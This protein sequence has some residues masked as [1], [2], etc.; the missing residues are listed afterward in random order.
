[1]AIIEV[2]TTNVAAALAKALV[3]LWL[4]DEGRVAIGEGIIETLKKRFEDYH[5][6]RSAETLL[7]NVE[8]DVAARLE[9][10]IST[11]FRG[12]AENEQEAAAYAVGN[13]IGMLSIQSEL[14]RA[15]LDATRLEIAVDAASPAA[16]TS[17]GVHTPTY[18]LAKHLLTECCRY[19]VVMAPQ[20]PQYDV[21]ATRELLIRGTT[22]LQ[23]L[24]SVLD[25]LDAIKRAT[26][27]GR[28][29]E[30]AEFEDRYRNTLAQILDRIEIFG[31]RITGAATREYALTRAYVPISASRVAT[32]QLCQLDE[33][34]MQERLVVVRGDAGSGKSTLMQWLAVQA[35]RRK[36]VA[37]LAHWNERIPFYVRLREYQDETKELPRPTQF[38]SESLRHLIDLVPAGWTDQSLSAGALLLIDGVDELPAKRRGR[39]FDW[40]RGLKDA[41]P[42]T[43]VLVS[44]RPAALD[45]GDPTFS[46]RLCS[47]GFVELALEPMTPNDSET[48]TIR[49]HAE[50]ARGLADKAILAAL[51]RNERS[52]RQALRER[53]AIRNLASSP[54]LCAMM[55]VLNWDQ[56]SNL[57]D[58]RMQ[59]YRLALDLLLERRESDREIGPANI[60]LDRQTKET[61][62]DGLAYW[63]LRNGMTEAGRPE[64]EKQIADMLPGLPHLP[65]SPTLIMDELVERS[66]VLRQPQY[67]V[68]DFQHRT[69]PEYM[70]ARAALATGDKGVLTEHAAIESW[71]DVVVFAAGHTRGLE[72]DQFIRQLLSPGP[73]SNRRPFEAKVTAVCCLET[74]GRELD[75]GV[76]KDLQA[77]AKS[78]FP[79]QD[80]AQ[81]RI[82]ATVAAADPSLLQGHELEASQVIAA[83]IRC[84][85]VVGGP[86]MRQV[87]AGYSEHP[88]DQIDQEIARA[89]QMFDDSDFEQEVLQ[90]RDALFGVRLSELATADARELFLLL[91]RF[92]REQAGPNFIKT[93]LNRFNFDQRLNLSEGLPSPTTSET[94]DKENDRIPS[95][96]GGGSSRTGIKEIVRIGHLTGLRELVLGVVDRD[97]L[98]T[99]AKLPLM[100]LTFEVDEPDDLLEFSTDESGL[101]ELTVGG[102][103]IYDLRSLRRLT[104]LGALSI[105]D[106]ESYRSIDFIGYGS[107]LRTISLT[108]CA[109]NSIAEL[110]SMSALESLAIRGCPIIDYSILG[111]LPKLTKLVLGSGSRGGDDVPW[112]SMSSLNELN[113]W[114]PDVTQLDKIG[115]APCLKALTILRYKL[116]D[117][118][119]IP[120]TVRSVEIWRDNQLLDLDGIERLSQLEHFDATYCMLRNT[121]ALLDLPALKSVWFFQS[122][123]DFP[124]LVPV[125][126]Q[127]GVQVQG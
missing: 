38:L 57:P 17:L 52:L 126:K 105:K 59:L 4:K 29:R 88:G 89:Y 67:G 25:E 103:G 16:F 76:L 127:R 35:A 7:R 118:K 69:F 26:S 112:S 43:V 75:A 121:K 63:M 44:S 37:A 31:V 124:E 51:E 74:V 41:Y 21:A 87:I 58:D 99:L 49:W 27:D 123:G 62:L 36:F 5:V 119:R 14:M 28:A 107:Q 91:L 2:L 40:I 32:D 64:A 48:L 30:A 90:R 70:G 39:L 94:S 111:E 120:T 55:C 60:R 72:R 45:S 85:A 11:E 18:E 92:Y 83:C 15:D 113:V 46:S 20:L 56:R 24:R 100:R 79:P 33:A 106:A 23:T 19:I 34:L 61:L 8:D 82:L 42:N 97:A 66:G 125:L 73:V 12:L 77:L 114:D 22:I 13:A 78:L 109:V 117:I 47:L 104:K 101:E 50:V 93:G 68:V 122:K 71:R 96:R 108:Y 1:M 98:P 102:R 81:A 10:F 53:P 54:L 65:P 95:L 110:A 84:A 9:R 86:V 80:L 116:E 6:R 3:K 115:Q